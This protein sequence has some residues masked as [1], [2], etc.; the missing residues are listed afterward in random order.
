MPLEATTTETA[1]A[2]LQGLLDVAGSQPHGGRVRQCPAHQDAKPSLSVGVGRDGRVLLH[3]FGGCTTADVLAALHCAPARLFT[4][5]PVAPATYAHMTRLAVT[6]PP[7][8]IRRGHPADRGYRLEAVH[9][10]GPALLERWRSRSGDKELIWLTRRPDGG[11]IPG[12]V[13]ITLADLPL[14][15][16][17][18]V[19]SAMAVGD[20][21]LLVESES[22]VDALTGWTATT[23]AGGADAV[24]VA[25]VASVLGAYDR[26][27][28]IPDHDPAGLRWLRRLQA[29]G[30]PLRV[31]LPEPGEDA[32]DHHQRLGEVAFMGAVNRALH[33]EAV[34]A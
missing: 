25:R 15:R 24:N 5:P 11:A 14:Y 9:D 4:A 1:Y 13:G 18:E 19:W 34:A 3:C 10:Y 23:W 33:R 32:R 12:L 8:E 21:V 17:I 16:E 2:W 31:L 20:P 22:S 26:T 28:A 30:V 6:F 29:V 27:I 7:V